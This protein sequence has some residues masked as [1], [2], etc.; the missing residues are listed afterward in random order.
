MYE[1]IHYHLDL[2]SY[3]RLNTGIIVA[4]ISYLF[5]FKRSVRRSLECYS[6]NG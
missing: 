5:I 3:E 6:G 1:I 4:M 2:D